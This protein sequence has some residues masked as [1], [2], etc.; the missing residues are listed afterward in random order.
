MMDVPLATW[1]VMPSIV[2]LTIS[3]DVLTG[4]P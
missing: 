4:V 1:L 2:T 3:V